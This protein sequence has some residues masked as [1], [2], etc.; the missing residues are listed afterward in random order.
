MSAGAQRRCQL[1]DVELVGRFQRYRVDVRRSRRHRLV[2][3]QR[4]GGA[5]HPHR[6]AH[7]GRPAIPK[8]PRES[9]VTTAAAQGIL[10]TAETRMLVLED[11]ARVVVETADQ[12]GIEL[13]RDVFRRQSFLDHAER[14]SAGG[15]EVVDDVRRVALHRLVLWI[16]G[17]EQ[18]KRVLLE[19][20]P[21]LFAQ[22]GKMRPIV[23]TKQ[24]AVRGAADFVA[25]AVQVQ[26]YT[27]DVERGKPVPTE[28]DGLHV[29]HRAAVAEGF[30][31]KLV[32]LS[33]AA[34]LGPVVPEI[35]PHVV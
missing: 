32:E 34:G 19:A 20:R 22:L 10:R 13:E 24:V 5:V 35:W 6:K 29:K 3:P 21:A 1:K 16:L 8:C 25:D 12:L 27:S 28:Q 4:D 30:D 14:L 17:I 2:L 31:S 23:L 15:A 9:V 7:T 33:K 26:G 11:R 18:P